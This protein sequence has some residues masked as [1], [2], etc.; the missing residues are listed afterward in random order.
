MKSAQEL[1]IIFGGKLREW[2]FLQLNHL[3]NKSSHMFRDGEGLNQLERF[4][5]H[6]RHGKRVF[7]KFMKY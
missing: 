3:V 6:Q 4:V 2:E 5:Q 7:Q 1:E